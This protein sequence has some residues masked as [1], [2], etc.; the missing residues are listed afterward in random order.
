M[1]MWRESYPI[2][3]ILAEEFQ[4][5][6]ELATNKSIEKIDQNRIYPLVLAISTAIVRSMLHSQEIYH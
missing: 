3:R 6:Q 5:K 4:Q 1:Y 2:H